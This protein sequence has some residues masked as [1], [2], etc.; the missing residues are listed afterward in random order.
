M[1]AIILAGGKGT[2]LRPYTT[3]LPKPLM[4]IDDRPILELVLRLLK[5]HNISDIYITLGYL[6]HLIKAV[7]GDGKSLG[8]NIFYSTEEK[9]LGTAGPVSLIRDQ[10]E[11]V[12]LLMNGDILSDI[13][14]TELIKFHK[15]R[16]ALMTLA[17]HKRTV[18][19]DYGV[20]QID[21]KSILQKYVEKPTLSYDVSMGI[22]VL[23]RKAL[24]F[25]NPG[26]RCD[27][28]ELAMKI[29]AKYPDGVHCYQTNAYWLDIGR[30]DD[31]QKAVDDFEK[32]KSVFD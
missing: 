4:P 30:Q 25:L 11:D 10:L 27:I 6:G 14:L 29:L 9:P 8:L 13:D 28:P 7:F 31:Y 2:R 22:N 18:H 26:E 20:L 23:S 12:F 1:Q 17:V 32:I 3:I 21:E 24:D 5:K 16:N 19:I 15:E